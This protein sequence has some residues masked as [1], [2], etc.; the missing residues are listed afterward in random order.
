LPRATW[1]AS[2]ARGLAAEKGIDLAGVT[3]SWPGGAIVLADV[4]RA[5]G[6]ADANTRNRTGSASQTGERLRYRSH[7]AR[8]RCGNGPV[9]AGNSALL[10]DPGGGSSKATD[11]L[12]QK[13]ADV[14]PAER[15]LMG[16]LFVKATALAA[17]AVDG[18]NGHFDK[19]G[20]T[21]PKPSTQASR[22]HCAAVVW[23]RRQSLLPMS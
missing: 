13:N 4:E 9:Q 15:L 2:P 21:P 3:G 22:L 20:F 17:K 16:A 5:T 11:W 12:A 14:G 7:A 6:A 18:I 1:H 10:H 8:H 19:D 23:S